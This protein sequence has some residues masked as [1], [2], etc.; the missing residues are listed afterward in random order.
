MDTWKN[1]SPVDEPP[2]PPYRPFFGRESIPTTGSR[3]NVLEKME[4]HLGGWAIPRLPIWIVSVQT[5]LYLAVMTGQVTAG[6]LVLIPRQVLAGESWRLLTFAFFPP[7]SN[8]LFAFFAF[9]LFYLMGQALEAHWGSFRFNLFLLAGYLATLAAAF[10]TAPAQGV[11]PMFLG[12]SVFLAFAFLYP[13]FELRLFFILPVRIKWLA[14]L[15]WAGYALAL[16]VGPWSERFL[17]LAATFNFFLFFGRDLVFR[18]KALKRRT[19]FAREVE[20]RQAEP[21]HRCQVCGRT[22]RSDPQLDFVY[23]PTPEGMKCFCREHQGKARP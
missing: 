4:K 22:D 2:D 21:F 3:M 23:A 16:V 19:D 12:G 13:D 18:T 6:D 5:L 11:T 1:E 20:I 15:T 7:L 10:G 8:P 17:I 9:Y 14:A